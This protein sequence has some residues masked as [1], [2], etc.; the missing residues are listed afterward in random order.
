MRPRPLRSAALALAF[1]AAPAAAHDV[2]PNSLQLRP[3]AAAYVFVV[4][5]TTCAADITAKSSNAA[6]AKVYA[7][8][9]NQQDGSLL[10]GNGT[11]VTVQD[12]V[13]Q[14][15]VVVAEAGISST[16]SASI[17][18][19]WVG[20][21]F[22]KAGPCQENNCS[23]YAP[24]VV[25]LTVQ[26]DA[27]NFGNAPFAG[28]AGDPIATAT[29]E[30][31]I[32]EPQDLLLRGPLPLSFARRYSSRFVAD[33][34]TAT[35]LG[36][37]WRHSFDWSLADLGEA[38]E[39]TGADGRQLRFER[40]PFDAAWELVKGS[41]L[42]FA[43]IDATPSGFVLRDP[44]AALL[45]TF[46]S[47]GR[48]TRIADGKGNELAL[49]Y[50]SGRL[51]T[52]SDGLGR[53]L[54]LSYDGS[55]RLTQVSDGTRT[56]AFGYDGSSRLASV[57]DAESGVTSYAYSA[58]LPSRALLAA[59]TRP[60]GNVPWTQAYDTSGRVTTQADAD[61]HVRTFAYDD[62][63]GVTTITAPDLSTQLHTH[64][65]GRLTRL[66]FEN[67]K[68][69]TLAYDG[70][71]RRTQVVDRRGDRATIAWDSAARL[72]ASYTAPDGALTRYTWTARV[73]DG[74]TF[75]DLTRVTAADGSF[76]QFSWDGDGNVIARI[77]P[78]G[79]TWSRTYGARGELLTATAAD[80]GV[81]QF[82]WTAGFLLDHAIDA[83]GRTTSFS[84][85][86]LGRLTDVDLP[87]GAMRHAT[88]DALDRLTSV[89]DEAGGVTTFAWDGNSNLVGALLPGNRA[90]SFAYDAMDRCTAALDPEG[91]T[92]TF[93]FDPLG[94]P[95]VATDGGGVALAFDWTP[96][97]RLAG[98]TDGL[99]RSYALGYDDEAVLASLADDAGD[100][101]AYASS[102]RGDWTRATSAEGRVETVARD[103]LGRVTA[104]VDGEGGRTTVARDDAG[105]VEEVAVA[106]AAATLAIERDAVGRVA[107]VGSGGGIGA[108]I[109]RD[110]AGEVTA[111][112]DPVGRE[113]L[114]TLDPLGRA[115]SLLLP[116][117]LGDVTITRDA[118]GKVTAADW[119]D[120]TALDWQHDADGRVV[121]ATGATITRDDVGR[122][123]VSNGIPAGRDGAGRLTSLTLA[124][125]L[126]VT[127]QWDAAGRLAQVADDDG[128]TCDFTWDP[129]GRLATKSF[130]NGVVERYEWDGDGWLARLS[131]DGPLEPLADLQFTRDDAGRIVRADRLQPVVGLPAIGVMSSVFDAAGQDA[132]F[133]Y[134]ALGRRLADD[135]RTFDWDL[136]GRLVGATDGAD[137]YEFTWDGLGQVVSGRLNADPL[138]EF[139]WNY[140]T[141]RPSLGV[142]REGGIDEYA[143]VAT[144]WGEPLWRVDL[145]D[146]ERATY[147]FDEQGNTL[148]ECDDF[149]E[150]LQAYAWGPLGELFATFAPLGG[151]PYA[152]LGLGGRE[153]ALSLGV[154]VAFGDR[155]W[156]TR[157]CSSLQ[158]T[159][160]LGWLAQP[161]A[162]PYLLSRFPQPGS[163]LV[164]SDES[165]SVVLD[166]FALFDGSSVAN[167]WLDAAPARTP[168]DFGVIGCSSCHPDGLGAIGSAWLGAAARMRGAPLVPGDLM[169]ESRA[170]VGATLFTGLSLNLNASLLLGLR[171]EL[172]ARPTPPDVDPAA[173]REALAKLVRWRAFEAWTQHGR[174]APA[175]SSEPVDLFLEAFLRGFSTPADRPRD[176]VGADAPSVPAPSAR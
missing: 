66:A 82:G 131:V 36:P 23:P 108:A 68:A 133:T 132:A 2:S 130:G 57:T 49:A 84:Y 167:R 103:G 12:R 18:V 26:P 9:M 62:A 92:A 124:G 122:V 28:L 30:L 119:S 148:L 111:A 106:K 135:T 45:R 51:A 35:R 140:A 169:A 39:V 46:D 118:R 172:L 110:A 17:E 83:E 74:F 37:G 85:D 87:G 149:G 24:H 80:G 70:A 75:H 141:E 42:P 126:S 33:G 73:D 164:R 120:G 113:L 146:G 14:V 69:A 31:W 114:A 144:P 170:A 20:V 155:I 97:G 154:G 161:G 127:Y 81:R 166:T 71:G 143:Y 142:V 67:G 15:F 134:D 40:G 123:E 52:V 109:A 27:E 112:V 96:G 176:V 89:T 102:K 160:D 78:L 94:R 136:A 93:T 76:E 159:R 43:L 48:M 150:L 153:N 11:T 147:H 16:Q 56:V 117:G 125:T 163:A 88:W 4:D 104:R 171:R 32:D 116:G 41:D 128:F 59:T 1:L 91:A 86:G 151:Y 60:E 34:L 65:G 145:I 173:S 7:L 158:P 77:D 139:D 22:G 47:S 156:D 13:D 165:T 174:P 54:A 21:D 101:F 105:R 137:S 152:L 157:H 61:G 6:V 115:G 64:V 129:V 90:W 50:A 55:S 175:P 100:A 168:H 10:P 79:A 162:T 58:T 72:P 107:R 121:G 95:S 98:I 53:Q 29:G 19:C 8:D 44:V 138:V 99:G 25:A 5:P 63:T 38:V 3:G